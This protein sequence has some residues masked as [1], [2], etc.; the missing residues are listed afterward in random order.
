MK[1]FSK[2]D[3]QLAINS[4]KSALA[5]S[6]LLKVKYDTFKRH[7]LKYDLFVKNQGGKG[8]VKSDK[9]LDQLKGRSNIKTRLFIT[10]QKQNIC[11]SCG[12]NG[13]WL[14]KPIT[15]EL[16]HINGVNNDNKIENLQLLCPNCHSQTDNFRNKKRVPK[17]KS[18]E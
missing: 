6:K 13:E 12:I 4:T 1:N 9:T 8:I 17:E 16:H 14:G 18:L 3:I 5:A 2:E 11:E 15:L 10:G 7:A